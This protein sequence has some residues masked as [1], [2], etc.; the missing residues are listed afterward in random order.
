MASLSLVSRVLPSS[1]SSL[2]CE[3]YSPH[4]LS[5]SHLCEHH[6]ISFFAW[7]N[8]EIGWMRKRLKMPKGWKWSKDEGSS[9]LRVSSNFSNVKRRAF[10]LIEFYEIILAA[11]SSRKE[12]LYIE[13]N[14][15]HTLQSDRCTCI[16]CIK[17]INIWIILFPYF[18]IKFIKSG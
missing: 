13:L 18:H 1:R 12:L 5:S 15:K 3:L 14:E 2:S 16:W 7:W 17:N 10:W 8:L 11:M 6:A 9:F 4:P